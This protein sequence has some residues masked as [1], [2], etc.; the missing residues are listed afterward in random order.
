M[1][2][3][4]FTLAEVLIT[5][6]IIGIIAAVAAPA[7]ASAKPDADKMLYLKFYN[8]IA[9]TIQDLASNPA[10]FAP[11]FNDNGTLRNVSKEPL[12]NTALPTDPRFSDVSKYQGENKLGYIFAEIMENDKIIENINDHIVGL[13]HE[14][15]FRRPDGMWFGVVYHNDSA[16]GGMRTFYYTIELTFANRQYRMYSRNRPNVKPN[17]FR[18]FVSGAGK[19]Y[20]ADW[21]GQMYADTRLNTSTKRSISSLIEEG[22]TAGKYKEEDAIVEEYMTIN[23]AQDIPPVN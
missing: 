5:L 16:A 8:H 23:D 10:I 22:I 17:S 15:Q 12:Y 1:K 21:C 19:V 18:F 9:Q 13:E 6:G 20:P 11:M 4:A 7:I 14:I 3:F 2:K